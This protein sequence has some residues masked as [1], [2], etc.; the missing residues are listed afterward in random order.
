MSLKIEETGLLKINSNTVIFNE[1]EKIENL[2]VITK[3]DI[4]V[5]ISSKDLINTENKEDI[6]QNSCKLF[7]IPRNIIIGIGGYRENSNYMFSLKSNSENEVYIIKTSNKEEIKDF[8]NKNK[9]YLT[10]MYH[11]TS[12]LSLKFYE[13]YI[14]IKNIN[15][16]LKTISTNSGIAYF[17]INSKNKHLKSESFLKI[18]EIFESATKS[19]FY[20]PHSFDVDFVKSNH[21]ELSDY[22]KDLS[23]EENDNKLNVEMEYIRRF[24]TMPKNIK[25]SFFT[26]DTNM[27]L[28]P[29]ICFIII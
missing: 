17:N 18:K 10:N 7:S 4:D 3:G 11:S 12:Y 9:P 8:F 1:G 2:L 28:S 19:G 26:Y 15:N 27:S 21:K 13:E 14:K 22:N 24:L 16:E 5:Y 25:D 23:K 20:I 6:I 29:E